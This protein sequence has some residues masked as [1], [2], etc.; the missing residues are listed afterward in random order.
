[1][2]VSARMCMFNTYLASRIFFCRVPVQEGRCLHVPRYTEGVHNRSC[3]R[4]TIFPS[5]SVLQLLHRPIVFP[6]P[7]TAC[8]AVRESRVSK[9]PPAEIL[10]QEVSDKV[11]EEHLGAIVL[12]CSSSSLPAHFDL[13]GVLLPRRPLPREKLTKMTQ[14]WPSVD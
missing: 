9:T 2:Y 7:A 3:V 11:F 14:W 8:T 1:V 12:Y 5:H 6:T 10:R 13:A 4:S